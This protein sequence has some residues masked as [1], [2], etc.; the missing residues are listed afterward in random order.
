MEIRIFVRR[1]HLLKMSLQE[2]IHL[3]VAVGGIDTQKVV[4]IV[5]RTGDTCA[6]SVDV[7]KYRGKLRTPDIVVT[8][9]VDVG[10]TK[11]RR[12]SMSKA[13]IQP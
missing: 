11:C 5:Q 10:I 8:S 1:M 9:S 6:Y 7:L 4:A 2:V 3:S 12:N 13:V